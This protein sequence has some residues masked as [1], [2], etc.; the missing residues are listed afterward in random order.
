MTDTAP[1]YT[2]T[3]NVPPRRFYQ[4]AE[5]AAVKAALKN[6]KHVPVLAKGEA[7]RIAK[8]TG[9]SYP[10]VKAI[11]NGCRGAHVQLLDDD[12]APATTTAQ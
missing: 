12:E 11:F 8:E 10:M 1:R 6:A 5:I 3:K 9:V 7:E 4:P 2:L